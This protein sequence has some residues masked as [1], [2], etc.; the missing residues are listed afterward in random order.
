MLSSMLPEPTHNVC[1]LGSIRIAY[2]AWAMPKRRFFTTCSTRLLRNTTSMLVPKEIR[3]VG[4]KHYI[5]ED[6]E[7]TLEAIA[8]N[9]Q[10]VHVTIK[11]TEQDRTCML[12]T[13]PIGKELGVVN[14]DDKRYLEQKFR[15]GRSYVK[16]SFLEYDNDGTHT[17]ILRYFV[18]IETEKVTPILPGEEWKNWTYT[19][20][21]FEDIENW[22]KMRYFAELLLE[23]LTE[24][25]EDT[26][27]I[28]QLLDSL[29]KASTFNISYECSKALEE[30]SSMLEFNRT[31]KKT[32]WRNTIQKVSTERRA[33]KVNEEYMPIWW[34]EYVNN[35]SSMDLRVKFVLRAKQ[36]SGTPEKEVL[37]ADI[38]A[39]MDELE[40]QLQKLPYDLYRYIGNISE[41]FE[42]AY[43]TMIPYDKLVD[44][45]SA[46]CLRAWLVYHFAN[47]DLSTLKCIYLVG[48]IIATTVNAEKV[49][50]DQ[51]KNYEL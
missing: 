5:K 33:K 49:F 29:Q 50:R 24:S 27:T 37:G 46:L 23:K 18:W 13:T 20:P 9:K 32:E 43:Y 42:H 11:A 21:R 31:E 16:M 4:L 38:V 35:K 14:A 22:G 3:V 40:I 7:E 39:L 2:M 47:K 12:V 17:P 8:R 45:L 30:I 25:E 1:E 10:L 6:F 26:E 36:K 51:S 15:D 41:F 28:E 44:V 34:Q 48:D 19:F